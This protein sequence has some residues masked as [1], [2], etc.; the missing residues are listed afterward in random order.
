MKSDVDL[1]DLAL[2]NVE[3]L[4][5]GESGDRADCQWAPDICSEFV[6]Y[7]G[8]DWGIDILLDHEKKPGWA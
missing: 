3:A 6:K 2:A 4:A 5:Q 8:G 1:S 7:P